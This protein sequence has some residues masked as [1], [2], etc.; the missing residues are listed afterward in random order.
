MQISEETFHLSFFINAQY[1]PRNL[2]NATTSIATILQPSLRLGCVFNWNFLPTLPT[3]VRQVPVCLI[4]LILIRLTLTFAVRSRHGDELCC[5]WYSQQLHPLELLLHWM[6]E[7]VWWLHA[8]FP[9]LAWN[10]YEHFVVASTHGIW[11]SVDTFI[12]GPIFLYWS[13]ESWDK[14][15]HG[16]KSWRWPATVVYYSP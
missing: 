8:V 3:L 13:L 14:C 15:I 1:R 10:F 5:W 7:K 11:D 4:G 6:R 12:S 2:T 16:Q 9:T